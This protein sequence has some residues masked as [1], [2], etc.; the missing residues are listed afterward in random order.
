VV[1]AALVAADPGCRIQA[2]P[3]CTGPVRTAK[4]GFD[5]KVDPPMEMSCSPGCSALPMPAGVFNP[6]KE[7]WK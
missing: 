2:V 6:F 3:R 5:M 7:T 1:V 4:N